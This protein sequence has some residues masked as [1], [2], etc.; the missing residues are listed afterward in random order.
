MDIDDSKKIFSSFYIVGCDYTNLQKY[1]EEENKDSSSQYIQNIDLLISDLFPNENIIKKKNEKWLKIMKGSNTWFRIKYSKE[2]NNPITELKIVECNQ[3]KNAIL[4]PKKYIDKGYRPI[5]ITTFLK[6]DKNNEKNINMNENL[7]PISKEFSQ[8]TNYNDNYV[9]IPINFNAKAYMQLKSK[10]P[11]IVLAISRSFTM[12][13]FKDIYIKPNKQNNF[14][15]FYFYRHNSPFSYQ[16]MPK[17]LDSYPPEQDPNSSIALFCFPEGIKI[18]EEFSMPKWF[19][20]VLTNQLGERTYGTLLYFKEDLDSE[21]KLNEIFIPIYKENKSHFI[22]KGI[23]ILSK[24]PFYYNS[25]LLLKELYRI[26]FGNGTKIPLE[27]IICNFVDTLYLHSYDKIIRYKINELSLDFYQISSYGFN[28]DTNF[29]YFEILFRILDYNIIITAWK[30]LL[31]E[32]KLFILSSSKSTLFQVANG[33]INL[34]FPFIWNHI[35]IPILPEKMKLFMESPVPSLIGISFKI[36]IEEIPDDGLIL[37]IDKNCFEKYNNQNILPPLPPKLQ[38]RLEKSLIKIKEKYLDDYPIN[39]KE[40]INYQDE[41][42]PHYELER[43]PKIN[44]F[45]IRDAFYNIFIQIFKNYEKFLILDN[46]KKNVINK[47]K[48]NENQNIFLKDNFLKNNDALDNKFLIMFLDTSLFTQFI[49]CFNP[50]EDE[51]QKS[52]VIFL[53]SIKKGREK[54]KLYFKDIKLDKIE[55]AQKIDVSDLNGKMFFYSGFQKLDKNLFIHYDIPK[56]PYKSNFYY[57]KDEWCYNLKKLKK[58]D[59]QKY[60]F[61]IIHDIWF[62]FFSYVLNFYEDNQ[63][64]ILMDYTLSLIEDIIIKKKIPPTRNTFSKIIKS[65]GRNALTPFMKQILKLVNQVYKNNK[66][67]SLFQ[68]DYL[69]GLYILSSKEKFNSNLSIGSNSIK[70]HS[71]S[72]SDLMFDTELNN[73]NMKKK[74]KEI[75]SYLKKIIFLT[76][77]LCPNCFINRQVTKKISPEEILAGFYLNYEYNNI[78]KYNE[79]NYTLCINCMTRFQPKIYYLEKNQKDIMPKEIKILSPM[80]LIKSIDNIFC[81][82][83]E[84]YFYSVKN[85]IINNIYLNVIFYFELFDLPLCVLYVQNDM[86]KFE[87]I[88]DQL[89]VNLERKN[90]IK[91]KHQNG[92]FYMTFTPNNWYELNQSLKEESDKNNNI[93]IKSNSL[94]NIKKEFSIAIEE[95]KN[96]WKNI[97][98]KLLENKNLNLYENKIENI[99]KNEII[100]FIKEMKDYMKDSLNFFI[101]DSQVKLYKFLINFEKNKQKNNINFAISDESYGK[102]ENVANNSENKIKNKNRLFSPEIKLNT[103]L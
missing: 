100:N 1:K 103:R 18:T 55:I 65:L 27:R 7:I 3:D 34:L 20:F 46:N 26:A 63:A 89:K 74:Y 43:Y 61:F 68:N 71:R 76:S 12:L 49:N 92:D 37:N 91:R 33:L 77:D 42:F 82:K 22:D 86:D 78:Q 98:V 6:K 62:T 15:N 36:E 102:N 95:E 81:E 51:V 53:E 28:F 14:Y 50:E 40:Y 94:F 13:A 32:K 97:Q 16:F 39:I 72:K 64:I 79:N 59:W 52:M 30:C 47:L 101:K 85:D 35:F 57:Y 70:K 67:N 75:E 5:I 29:N 21:K 2:Y 99:E 84:M 56:I 19:N 10:K 87:K 41:A 93:N 80:N 23:C 69:N 96:L 38:N 44:T 73:K 25:K 8:I 58:E 11:C 45:E 54:D 31:L 4:F 48:E 88:K 83:G 17:I 9:I 90:I 24:Y 66:N 60:F